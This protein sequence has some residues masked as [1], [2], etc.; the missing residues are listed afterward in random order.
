MISNIIQTREGIQINCSTYL[1]KF[2]KAH[3]WNETSTKPLEP[4]SP[5]KVMELENTEGP[6]INSE[7][8]KLLFK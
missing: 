6:N 4:I 1:D 5:C 8:G 2:R 7:E 3:G